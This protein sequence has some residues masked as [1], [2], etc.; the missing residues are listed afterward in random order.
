LAA[1]TPQGI[2]V[3]QNDLIQFSAWSIRADIYQLTLEV[4]DL[5]GVEL[6]P[7]TLT[8]TVTSDRSGKNT[9]LVVTS[10]LRIISASLTQLSGT[11]PT[12]PGETFVQL[13][14]FSGA[15]G[16]TGKQQIATLFS[17]YWYP[18]HTPSYPQG[19]IESSTEGP[20]RIVTITTAVPSAGA[21]IAAQAVPAGARWRLRAFTVQLVQGAT[22][23]P[24]PTL[25]FRTAG[26]TVSA[27]IPVTTTAIA[28]SSTSQLTWGRGLVQSSFTAVVGDEF[29]TA[30]L[31]ELPM[32]PTDDVAT[33]TDGIGANT[34]Y[35]AAQ[36]TIEEWIETR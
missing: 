2:A 13:N 10:Q 1:V 31:P 29:H 26:A 30:P 17:G 11:L 16:Q 7:I 4:V 14:V 32:E 33:K 3:Q 18:G 27:Q 28:V 20:A 24:L 15:G 9:N 8:Q 5:N 25:R 22:Q 23:T 36:L 21:E 12:G 34:A 35:G 19:R 6:N